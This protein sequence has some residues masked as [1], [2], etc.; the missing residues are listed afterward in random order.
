MRNKLNSERLFGPRTYPKV[1]KTRNSYGSIA[2]Y[3]PICKA[4][5]ESERLPMPTTERPMSHFAV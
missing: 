4:Y 3:A 1:K 5:R 2:G